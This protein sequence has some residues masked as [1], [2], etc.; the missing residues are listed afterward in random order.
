MVNHVNI[1][2]FNQSSMDK[3]I[4][5]AYGADK[6]VTNNDIVSGTFSLSES[7]CASKELKFGSLVASRLYRISALAIPNR[8]V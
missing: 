4:D 2:K 8:K 3:Q 5:I 1:D 7:G 6:H